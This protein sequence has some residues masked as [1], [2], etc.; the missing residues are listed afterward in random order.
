MAFSF[1]I[2][3]LIPTAVGLVFISE[4]IQKFLFASEVGAGRFEKIGVPFPEITGYVTGGIEIVA[5]LFLLLQFQR[6]I[7][8]SILL[9]IMGGA[10]WFTKIP[11]LLTKGFWVTAH[12]GRT[13]FLMITGLLYTA[14]LSYTSK[15][16]MVN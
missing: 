9:I 2:E 13:D 1:K 7:A 5:G 8:A 14:Y 12:E 10:V 15:K 11:T 3:N 6:L 16:K 4:G